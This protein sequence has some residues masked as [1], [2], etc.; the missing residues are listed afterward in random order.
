MSGARDEKGATVTHLG[1]N[2]HV[3]WPGGFLSFAPQ[4]LPSRRPRKQI[5]NRRAFSKASAVSWSHYSQLATI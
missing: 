5:G 3:D 4:I 2:T 1:H